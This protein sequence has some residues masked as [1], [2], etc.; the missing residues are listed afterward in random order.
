M[1]DEGIMK[2]FKT[3]DSYFANGK[4]RSDAD[5]E[6]KESKRTQRSGYLRARMTLLTGGERKKTIPELAKLQSGF[7]TPASSKKSINGECRKEPK[8][9]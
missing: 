5:D 1:A 7:A 9:P 2:V 4:S 6:G 8:N 3:G